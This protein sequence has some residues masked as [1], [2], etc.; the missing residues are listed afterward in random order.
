MFLRAFISALIPFVLMTDSLAQIQGTD[1]LFRPSDLIYFSIL[2]RESFN[3][4]FDGKP[5]YF[6]MIVAINANSAENELEIYQDWISNIIQEIR[7]NKFDRF[8]AEKKINQ[9][10]SSVSKALLI[11]FEHQ[12]SF[13]DLFSKGNF[14][15][16]TAASVY[17]I[18]LDQ[19]QIPYEIHEIST[20]VS[21]LA[22]PDD[23]QITIEID[24]P[25]S[26]F[27]RFE[28]GTRSNFVEFLRESNAIDEATFALVNSR[29]LF[30]RYYFTDYGLSIREMIGM[31]YLNSAIDYLNRSEPANAYAQFEKAFILYPC[32]KIQYLL[33]IELNSFLAVM[34]YYNL[35]DLGYLIKASR[36]IGFGM[37]REM[38]GSYLQDIILQV[39]TQEQDM[40][41]MQYIFD[42][43]Q[44]YLAD[45]A[46]KKDFSF[47][48]Y[49]ETGRLHFNDEQ[50][51]KALASSE[52]AYSLK[53]DDENN[54]NLLVRSLGGYTLNS[55]PGMVLEKIN[56]YDTAYTGIADNK[57]Y[58]MLKQQVCLEFFGEA[59][60][61]QDVK[62]GEH[63]LGIFEEI[64]DQ[65]PE[66]TID[67]LGVGRS[68]SSAAIY[69]YRKGLIH[70][71]RE[72]V[73]RGL[74]YAP[75][76]IEL[77]LK[78]KSFE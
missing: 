77:K 55:N 46:S 66:I 8:S 73:E 6:K 41:G 45:E 18:I 48:F 32:H 16:F 3:Q 64:A 53:P 40:K 44:E 47:R 33:M 67:Y 78:L 51:S 61:L 19:L 30:E 76:N 71:S 20:G 15:Y 50:Y 54:Q 56:L 2:E 4:Y 26:P 57:I 21:I 37:D 70:K 36:L 24:G 69:Y 14:N 7:L 12:S 38:I 10:M 1:T 65:H 23:E 42:Y 62:N 39:L 72:V 74:K 58:L 35:Q 68:Y 43:L 59:F 63:Y 60:Q 5:D 27:F 29:S 17:A 31:L 13:S 75:H 49:Y 52:T 34:D 22:Y 9:I 25:G 28:H 11:S